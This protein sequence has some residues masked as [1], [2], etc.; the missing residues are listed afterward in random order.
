MTSRGH[1]CTTVHAW[2]W[3]DPPTSGEL[4]LRLGTEIAEA[5]RSDDAGD[6][7]W[8]AGFRVPESSAPGEVWLAPANGLP[9]SRPGAPAAWGEGER[10]RAAGAKWLLGLRTHLVDAPYLSRHAYRPRHAYRRH[11]GLAL[12]TTPDLPVLFDVDLALLRTGLEVGDLARAPVPPQADE[13]LR[14]H[15]VGARESRVWAHTHGL[16]RLGLPELELADV[17][18]ARLTEAGDLLRRAGRWLVS[19][20]P[21]ADPDAPIPLAPH[22]AAE[23]R[24]LKAPPASGPGSAASRAE[25]D[26]GGPR[27][28]LGAPGRDDAGPLLEALAA[29]PPYLLDRDEGRERSVLA[30]HRWGRFGLAH[31]THAHEPGWRF[32]ASARWGDEL[33]WLEV[34]AVVPDRFRGRLA[35]APQGEYGFELGDEIEVELE[36]LSDWAVVTP[37]GKR[38]PWTPE[39]DA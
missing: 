3:D 13:L 37:T 14:I 2:P 25:G 39:S 1:P 9:T 30:R 36:R 18:G 22:L 19:R 7:V 11:L 21:D 26:H 29:R 20:G 5:G 15:L 38:D 35:S 23:P 17:P 34:L 28:V 16:Q 6:V 33:L 12:A 8:R 4:G 32:T 27:R 31:A 10:E 24:P